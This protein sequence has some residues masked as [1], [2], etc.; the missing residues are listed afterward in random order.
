MNSRYLQILSLGLPITAGMLSQSLLSLV[1]TAMVA[2]LNDASALA[3]V[4]V[5]SYANYLAV[6]LVIGLSVGVQTLVARQKGQGNISALA[7]PLNSG[8]L[9]ALIVGTLLTIL[10]YTFSETLI[11][12]IN[13][14]PAVQE[15]GVDYF[16]WRALGI[17]ALGINFAFRGY[18]N[19]IS[20]SMVYLKVLIFIQLANVLVSYGLIFGQFGMP[21]L[22]APGSGLGTTIALYLGAITYWFIT[23]RHAKDKGFLSSCKSHQ[24]S[25]IVHLALPNSIQHF[26][27]AMGIVI[28]YWLLGKVSLEAVAVGHALI[29]ISLFIMLPANGQGMAATTLV[30]QALGKNN[31]N[32]AYQWGWDSVKVSALLLFFLGLPLIF[33]APQILSLF[34]PDDPALLQL[35]VLPLQLTGASAVLQAVSI[36]LSQSLLGAGANRQVMFYSLAIQ[37]LLSLPLAAFVGLTLGYGLLGFWIVQ[38]IEKVIS[39]SVF[40]MLWK[41]QHWA[42]TF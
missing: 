40:A 8:L 38:V 28:Y 10:F 27:V 19:G 1:D 3:A 20:Q 18:W 39:A 42:K 37:W 6:A 22:G 29:N 13:N 33:Y 21:E 41:R 5:G 2:S 9:L 7:L 17:L 26:F 31:I 35:G 16:Q 25:A 34:T 23:Q 11:R 4:G 30:S 36:T 12:L 24:V 15:I 14:T 32:D